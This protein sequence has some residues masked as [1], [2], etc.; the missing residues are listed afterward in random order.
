M[1][2]KQRAYPRGLANT[3]ESKYQYGKGEI[4]ENFV[5]QIDSALEANELIKISVLETAPLSP[6]ELCD[7]LCRLLGADGV[8]VI[9]SK[10][11][12]YRESK[13]NKRIVLPNAKKGS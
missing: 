1:T 12:I 3:L 5:A 7:E 2:S 9:G 6:R 4:S 8:Q 10:V 13:K 11:V